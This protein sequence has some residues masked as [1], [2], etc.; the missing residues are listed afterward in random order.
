MGI[1]QQEEHILEGICAKEG[2]S[3]YSSG[4]PGA[5][6]EDLLFDENSGGPSER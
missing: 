5:D 3:M 1:S 6:L 2:T 4:G